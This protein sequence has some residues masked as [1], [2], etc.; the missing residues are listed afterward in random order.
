MQTHRANL[1]G[2]TASDRSQNVRGEHLHTLAG[3]AT[4]IKRTGDGVAELCLEYSV[5]ICCIFVSETQFQA[6]Q[7]ALLRNVSREGIIV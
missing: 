5:M 6:Q 4:E 2:F 1:N 7:T 3:R